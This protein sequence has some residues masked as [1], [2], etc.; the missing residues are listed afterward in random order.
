MQSR[1]GRGGTLVAGMNGFPLCF[2]G[3]AIRIT[4]STFETFGL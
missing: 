4:I 2:H 3:S 1:L